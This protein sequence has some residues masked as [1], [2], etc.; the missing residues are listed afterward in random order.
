MENMLEV[1]DLCVYVQNNGHL[2]K[3]LE[4]V[5]FTMEKGEMAGLVGE[6]GCGK[7]LTSLSVMGLL[8]EHAV[9]SGQ[10]KIGG[11]EFLSLPEDEKCAIRGKDVSMIFQ[12]PMTAL[13]PLIPVGRQIA[14]AYA[15]H[16]SCTRSEADDEALSIMK[17]VGLSRVKTGEI[18]DHPGHPYTQALLSAIPSVDDTPKERIIL[19]GEVPSPL[20]PPGGCAFHTRCFA[21]SERCKKECP[22]V[23]ETGNGH[24]VC[25]HFA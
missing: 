4:E 3:A 6:S 15:W 8:P 18:Y 9:C 14:E 1:R 16:H 11:K 24:F 12:E 25:C 7:S 13:N 2:N 5:S 10:I 21:A 19:E 20:A 23:K 22:A 17:K